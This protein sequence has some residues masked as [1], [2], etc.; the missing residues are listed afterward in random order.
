MNTTSLSLVS[1]SY[2]VR[3]Y[4]MKI[5]D[6]LNK[7]SIPIVTFI[8]MIAS[9]AL[10]SFKLFESSKVRSRP[11]SEPSTKDTPSKSVGAKQTP[12]H[13]LSPKDVEVV[14]SVVLVCSIFIMVQLLALTYT[15][16]RLSWSVFHSSGSMRYLLGIF[17]KVDYTFM[18]INASINIFVYYNYNSKFKSIIRSLWN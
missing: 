2:A 7:N 6:I 12:S 9:V 8:I 13:K 18:M 15:I 5:N 11:Y 1:D 17:L 10:L 3:F 16:M 4:K 14:Q